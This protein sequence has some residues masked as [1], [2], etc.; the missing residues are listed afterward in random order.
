MWSEVAECMQENGID[1]ATEVPVVDEIVLRESIDCGGVD[2]R[3]CTSVGFHISILDEFW[4][5]GEPDD[6]YWSLFRHETK[7]WIL[8]LATGNP[9]QNHSSIWFSAESPC[10]D[11]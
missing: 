10:P 3:A 7:H 9:D 5:D 4:H 11:E 1:M 8:G 2:A 6:I